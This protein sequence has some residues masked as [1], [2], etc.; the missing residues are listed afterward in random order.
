MFINDYERE[1]ILKKNGE[2]S[3]SDQEEDPRSNSP[4]YVEEQKKLKESFKQALS[5]VGGDDDDD[6][7]EW[8]GML[9]VR[10]KTDEEKKKEEADYFE[11]LAGQ[12]EEIEDKD[13]E[14]ELKPLKNYW[15]RPDLDE[16]EKFLRDYILQKKLVFC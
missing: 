7:E 16:E 11:W 12:K 15:N 10:Q 2:L 9:K 6:D 13:V 4:T 5:D 8:G 3:D 14:S 1:L